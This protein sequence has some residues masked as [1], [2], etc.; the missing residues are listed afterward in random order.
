MPIEQFTER[1][2]PVL[3]HPFKSFKWFA[4]VNEES[5]INTRYGAVGIIFRVEQTA[6]EF[7]VLDVAYWRRFHNPFR[8]IANKAQVDCVD[9]SY[10]RQ[11]RIPQYRFLECANLQ[12]LL[13]PPS[14]HRDESS[15]DR[16]YRRRLA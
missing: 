16:K 6:A 15:Q 8:M 4:M 1:P 7:S 11:G 3:S 9:S 2:I 14:K 10:N 12:T 13:L 5:G